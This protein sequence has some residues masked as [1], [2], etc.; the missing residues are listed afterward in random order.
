MSV[1]KLS[2][3]WSKFVLSS[4]CRCVLMAFGL[5]SWPELHGL[6]ETWLHDFSSFDICPCNIFPLASEESLAFVS[7]GS[8]IV[9]ERVYRQESYASSLN[10]V[11]CLK[12]KKEFEALIKID[13]ISDRLT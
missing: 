9:I 8:T 12:S 11:L 13:A 6:V 5:K 3:I 1:I 4:T 7:V 2:V 10:L